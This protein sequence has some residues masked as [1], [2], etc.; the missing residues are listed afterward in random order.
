M[1]LMI[2]LPI[3]LFIASF[4]SAQIDPELPN[5][6]PKEKDAIS[7]CTCRPDYDGSCFIKC[8]AVN[9]DAL[10]KLAQ[11]PNLCDGKIDFSLQHSRVKAIPLA[12]WKVLLTSKTVDV[13]IMYS[14]VDYLVAP[15]EGTLPALN[16]SGSA[17]IKIV[18]SKDISRWQWSQLK[19]YNPRFSLTLVIDDTPVNE[20]TTD[21]ADIA[22][23]NVRKV[24]IDIADLQSLPEG[25]FSKF[26][27]SY[28]ISVQNNHLADISRSMFPRPA[29]KLRFLSLNGN[30]LTYLPE[31][32]FSDMPGL[33]IVYL[34]ENELTTLPENIFM[35]VN[36]RRLRLIELT[37]NPWE[38]DC[39]LRKA[40]FNATS[41]V[42]LG[43]CATP[44]EMVGNKVQDL[45]TILNC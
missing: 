9:I 39:D 31:D 42:D 11:Y 25:I 23:G 29:P 7:P 28:S 19:S 12:L 13:S 8:Y 20:L 15:E 36:S 24:S 45:S 4:V 3:F 5:H 38:C 1:A 40:T 44:G 26:S 41:F 27:N 2:V 32:L 33:E 21:F 34:L 43:Y 10:R 30:D 18:H 37:R 35:S 6:C 16:T 17:I 14:K 22:G